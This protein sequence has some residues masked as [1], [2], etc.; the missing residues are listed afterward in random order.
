M[1]A[2]TRPVSRS[3]QDCELTHLDRCEIRY[4]LAQSQHEDYVAAL[5]GLGVAIIEIDPL[6]EHA[7]AVFVEDIIVVLDE[8][9][10]LTRP[11]A[12]SRRGEVDSIIAAIEP[13]REL[14][15]IDPPGTLEGGD[16]CVAERTVFVGE[17][18][19][20]NREGFDQLKVAL[21]PHGYH[22]VS[23]PVPGALHLKTAATYL[24][25]G[26]MLANPA[27]L[28]VSHFT[29]MNIIEVHPDE[30]MAGNA[31]R[32]GD[33]LLFSSQFPHTAGRLEARGFKLVLVDSTELAKAE[34]S[35]TCKSV[36]FTSTAP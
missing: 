8:I 19:R 26:Q 14:V 35:L 36:V 29:G 11:G 32:I 2:I 6:H 33:S 24:G 23:V 30:P 25:E 16:V 18:T 17:S 13:H 15:R 5:Q 9:A 10:V 7:D 22:V 34:G 4:E 28:D 3:I 21:S 20:T 31:I 12:E 1:Y 27:W